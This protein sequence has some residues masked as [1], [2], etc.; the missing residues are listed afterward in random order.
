[1]ILAI[2]PLIPAAYV[3]GGLVVGGVAGWLKGRKKKKKEQKVQEDIL[4]KLE[5]IETA[6]KKQEQD[7][8]DNTLGEDEEEDAEFSFTLYPKRAKQSK[9]DDIVSSGGDERF[10]ILDL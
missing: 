7:V 8:K 10:E 4:K 2:I 5:D 1:M 6:Q 3:A 9:K